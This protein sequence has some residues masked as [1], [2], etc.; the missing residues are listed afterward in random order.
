MFLNIM[1]SEQEIILYKKLHS[2]IEDIFRRKNLL[3]KLSPLNIDK[4][5][6]FI[7]IVFRTISKPGEDSD[8]MN[9]TD[10]KWIESMEYPEIYF[11]SFLFKK[12]LTLRKIYNMTSVPELKNNLLQ[13]YKSLARMV[14]FLESLEKARRL[15]IDTS[16]DLDKMKNKQL[17]ILI[18]IK[19]YKDPKNLANILDL[20]CYKQFR[21]N[22]LEHI[23]KGINKIDISVLK[24]ISNNEDTNII[25]L[26]EQYCTQDNIK[27]LLIFLMTIDIKGDVFVNEKLYNNIKNYMHDVIKHSCQI[28][29]LFSEIENTIADVKIPYKNKITLIV[30]DNTKDIIKECSASQNKIRLTKDIISSFNSFTNGEYVKFKSI[31]LIRRIRDII[32]IIIQKVI[33]ISALPKEEKV[34]MFNKYVK[35]YFLDNIENDED[36]VTL[37]KQRLNQSIDKNNSAETPITQ[38]V[39]GLLKDLLN[40]L[41][42]DDDIKELF[43]LKNEFVET[44]KYMIKMDFTNIDKSEFNVVYNLATKI[45]TKPNQLRFLLIKI[46]NA[47]MFKKFITKFEEDSSLKINKDIKKQISDKALKIIQ[48]ITES[49]VDMTNSK[50]FEKYI[51]FVAKLLDYGL[52]YAMKLKSVN[53][54]PSIVK[55]KM[56]IG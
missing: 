21:D 11:F 12:Q 3:N 31:D 30:L 24:G 20:L 5:K 37:D 10:D 32:F 56:V 1:S 26:I 19:N 9:W 4:D 44:L 15:F 38:K 23:V 6:L 22:F 45:L 16:V 55:Q 27:K 52:Y 2:S 40:S 43:V 41:S 53:L 7:D 54:K 47:E 49:L 18:N 34:I 39:K 14:K 13:S 36:F 35:E 28:Q 48:D 17:E 25:E 50:D 46:L 51:M 8:Y 29:K 42:E 33:E